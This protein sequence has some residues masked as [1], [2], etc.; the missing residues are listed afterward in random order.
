M[1]QKQLL[2]S[3][4]VDHP[5]VDESASGSNPRRGT[6]I[7][8]KPIKRLDVD[9][10][11]KELSLDDGS[12]VENQIVQLFDGVNLNDGSHYNVTNSKQMNELTSALSMVINSSKV[13]KKGGHVQV[14]ENTPA[15]QKT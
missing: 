1:L 4:V 11:R 14:S 3:A 15:Y 13:E 7:S 12:N 6:I 8:A 10:I 9:A 2:M 5:A